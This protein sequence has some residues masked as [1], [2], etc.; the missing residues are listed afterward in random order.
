MA[1]YILERCG[2]EVIPPSRISDTEM[3]LFAGQ[4]AGER[5][6]ALFEEYCRVMPNLP[7]YGMSNA[8]FGR[9]VVEMICS[10][11]PRMK[12]FCGKTTRGVK[13]DAKCSKKRI[14]IKGIRLRKSGGPCVM[15]EEWSPA[16]I[17][18]VR[19]DCVD[20]IVLGVF[21][22]DDQKFY[23]VPAK[24][25]RHM[26]GFAGQQTADSPETQIS[27]TRQTA[28]AWW[29]YEVPLSEI[30]VYCGS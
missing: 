7:L 30:E 11:N 21:A 22:L 12:R 10:N 5:W 18:R 9:H 3:L 20:H 4:V 19:A 16:N 27:F 2:R 25:V 1:A 6:P 24:Q 8:G 13:P 26:P 17:N 28:D 14:E 23:A 15:R 29:P